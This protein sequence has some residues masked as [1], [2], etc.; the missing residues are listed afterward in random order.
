MDVYVRDPRWVESDASG[1]TRGSWL[2]LVAELTR[3]E[4]ELFA[5]HGRATADA[6]PTPAAAAW[7]KLEAYVL[8]LMSG[9]EDVVTYFLVQ[10]VATRLRC[11]KTVREGWTLIDYLELL[12]DF[13]VKASPDRLR[14]GV[15]PSMRIAAFDLIH[16]FEM[17]SNSGDQSVDAVDHK[18]LLEHQLHMDAMHMDEMTLPY[19]CHP[20]GYFRCL[21]H[22]RPHVHH[23]STKFACPDLLAD[24]FAGL[25]GSWFERDRLLD[26]LEDFKESSN[27]D[28]RSLLRRE[29]T[30]PW[31]KFAKVR[32]S[33]V[34]HVSVL[35]LYSF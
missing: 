18:L 16:E 17:V 13:K 23:V 26:L 21:A 1:E 35:N 20:D 12:G 27:S 2:D 8:K 28:L 22:A 29:H 7:D 6:A 3:C 32:R 30:S 15:R 4:I 19:S 10:V 34:S 9:N 5:L 25:P 33:F 24:H 11:T 14:V 31:L